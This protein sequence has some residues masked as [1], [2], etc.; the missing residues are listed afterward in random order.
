MRSMFKGF[1]N[2]KP[3]ELK[4]IWNHEHTIFVF[5]TNCLLNLYRCEEETKQ[6]FLKVLETIKD[7]IWFPHHVCLEYQRNR[8]K[9]IN[10]NSEHLLKIKSS[11]ESSTTKIKENASQNKNRYPQLH[12]KL[13]ELRGKFDEEI[14]TFLTQEVDT[15]IASKDYIKNHDEVRDVI[16][17]LSLN[18]IGIPFTQDEIN[19]IEMEGIARYESETPPGF[20]DNAKTGSYQHNGIKY[21]NKFGDLVMWKEI[22]RFSKSENVKNVILISD[23]SKV[24][25]NYMIKENNIGPLEP[26]QTEIYS[27]CSLDNFKI[28]SQSS[29][30]YHANINLDSINVGASSI[31]EL[32]NLSLHKSYVYDHNLKIIEGGLEEVFGLHETMSDF[33]DDNENAYSKIKELL[34]SLI[35][36]RNNLLVEIED[37]KQ[38]ISKLKTE[39]S[40]C[41][42][43]SNHNGATY[44]TLK[45]L[46]KLQSHQT[47]LLKDLYFKLEGLNR[48]I[49]IFKN[50]FPTKYKDLEE[51]YR[52]VI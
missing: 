44:G 12:E 46:K 22:L 9:V 45:S 21:Q 32:D 18:R 17:N 14:R 30:L 33:E 51:Y 5:D 50:T 19:A 40:F 26:L 52:V 29:F 7:K 34:Q 49:E 39:L 2:P 25:W 4:G 43:E 23:D 41:L 6:D 16:D 13:E 24:D 28:Y 10:D 36:K 47:S 37:A 11:L 35:S 42:D 31:T 20:K 8:L 1:Y 27:E 48:K 3:D 38:H 15:R